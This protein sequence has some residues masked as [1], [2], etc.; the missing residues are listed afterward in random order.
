MTLTTGVIWDSVL[1]LAKELDQF[2][3][4]ERSIKISE[5]IKAFESGRVYEI[6]VVGTETNISS[7]GRISYKENEYILPKVDPNETLA[8]KLLSDL[9]AIQN[10]TVSRPEW[11]VIF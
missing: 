7:V 11:Q 2:P 3:V 6:F 10:G 5:L 4:I 8:G 1:T 9:R